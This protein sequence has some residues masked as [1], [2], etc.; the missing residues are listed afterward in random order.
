MRSFPE[1]PYP[2]EREMARGFAAYLR[3][4]PEFQQAVGCDV[5]T[6]ADEDVLLL[7]DLMTTAP[8][9]AEEEG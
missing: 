9:V 2:T 8:R 5:T 7:H 6:L 1:V 3:S 4:D